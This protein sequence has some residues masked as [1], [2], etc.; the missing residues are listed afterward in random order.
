MT[1][2]LCMA[3]SFGQEIFYVQEADR[4]T[5]SLFL[6]VYFDQERERDSQFKR[7]S[8]SEPV[9]GCVFWSR[10]ILSVQEADRVTVSLCMAY[11][12]FKRDTLR[13]RG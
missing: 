5:V 6:A 11:S 4:V 10:G 8:E 13:S 7:M 3:M 2:S 9:Y 1:A 12:L